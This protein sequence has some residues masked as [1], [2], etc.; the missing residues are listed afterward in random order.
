MFDYDEIDRTVRDNA[1]ALHKLG[2]A[3]KES[4]LGRLHDTFVDGDPRAL[5]ESFRYVPAMID[6]NGEDPY[7]H[8]PDIIPADT[9]LY[10]IIDY[11]NR[12]FVVFRG[13][14]ADIHVFIGDCDGLDEFYL[15]TTDCRRLYSVTDH[16]VL[17][18][19]DI[20]INVPKVAGL[21]PPGEAMDTPRLLLRRWRP[22]DA[23]A[24]YRYASDSR[25]SELALWPRHESVEMSREVITGYF[26]PDPDVFAIV[27]RGSGEPVGCIGLVPRGAENHAVA[28][29]EREV[30]YW[31]GYP[32]WG[33]G[34][35]TEALR[36][37]IDRCRGI[38][39]IKSLLITT[40]RRNVA[41]QRV[42]LKCGFAFVE[43]Y[44]HDGIASRAYRLAMRDDVR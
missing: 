14:M 12:D 32:L 39:Q 3:D 11:W 35:A 16:D 43:A 20:D 25:V 42:A 27:L 9:E 4:L 33:A 19:I 15:M 7:L 26:A 5:W 44:D 30:G 1:L 23:P 40:D 17:Y 6:C 28:A 13:R 22:D 31:L 36:A 38:P 21:Y 24:L 41:S 34:L 2:G 10:F 18:H 8:L 37:L 29:G